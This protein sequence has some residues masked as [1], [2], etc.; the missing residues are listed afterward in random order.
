V[1]TVVHLPAGRSLTVRTAADAFLDSLGNPNTVRNYGMGVGKTAERLG[2][3]RPLAAV[4]DEAIAEITCLL[5]PGDAR[6]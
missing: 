2:G 3:T 5:A 1:P 6:R 4:A